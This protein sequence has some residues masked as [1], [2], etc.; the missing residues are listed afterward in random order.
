MCFREQISVCCDVLLRLLSAVDATV[1]LHQFHD[2]LL[3]GL[4]HP[5]TSVRLLAL[6]QVHHSHTSI[7]HADKPSLLIVDVNS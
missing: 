6:N 7:S 3:S 1:I 4:S 2:D 5:Q